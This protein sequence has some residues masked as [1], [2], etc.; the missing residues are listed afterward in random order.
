MSG[1]R[2][3][4]Q[5]AD[6]D[7]AEE[8]AALRAGDKRVGA[9]CSFIGT[10]RDRNS[11]PTLG[12]G[13]SSLPPEGAQPALGRPGGGLKSSPLVE[14]EF[15]SIRQKVAFLERDRYLAPDIEAMRQW[16]LA[17]GMPRALRDILPSHS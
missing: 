14:A 5:T 12:T 1:A 11:A 9:V 7:L 17:A 13:V 15:A 16:A 6:F 8:V 2:V 10:V 3:S 4:I